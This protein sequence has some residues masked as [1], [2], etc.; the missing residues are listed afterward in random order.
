MNWEQAD[1]V[2][3]YYIKKNNIYTESWKEDI[4]QTARI[5]YFIAKENCKTEF[6]SKRIYYDIID[7]IRIEN[8]SKR[9]WKTN[10][11]V[12]KEYVTIENWDMPISGKLKR[13]DNKMLFEKIYD[14]ADDLEKK[15]IKM[16]L[17]GKK[18]KEI[19]E[20]L[21]LSE[22]RANQIFNWFSRKPEIAKLASSFS[23]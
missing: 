7:Q 19:G 23:I 16:K 17:N 1:K 8:E 9:D 10:K 12:T 6:I 3:N 14:L 11:Y 15:V 2:A 21:G 22:A 13:I 4:R 18:F 20:A 5:S